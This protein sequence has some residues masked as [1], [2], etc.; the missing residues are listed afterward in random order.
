MDW[1]G[2]SIQNPRIGTFFLYIY[3]RVLFQCDWVTHSALDVK[4]RWLRDIEIGVVSGNKVIVDSFGVGNAIAVFQ[5]GVLTDLSIDPSEKQ[6]FYPLL[7]V[8][9]VQVERRSINIGG[10]YIKLPNLKSGFLISKKKYEEG[11]HII[12]ITKSFFDRDKVQ[13]FSDVLKLVSRHFILAEGKSEIKFAK[14]FLNAERRKDIK[15]KIVHIDKIFEGKLSI[16]VRSSAVSVDDRELMDEL[17]EMS[18]ELLMMR[19]SKTDIKKV[20][21]DG[22]LSKKKVFNELLDPSSYEII[23]EKG[24]FETYGIWDEVGKYLIPK[25]ML[26]NGSNIIIEQTAAFCSIDVNSGTASSLGSFEINKS[27]IKEI[28]SN[29]NIRGISGKI[30]IDFLPLSRTLRNK[31]HVFVLNE[32]KKSMKNVIVY[33][34]TKGNSYEISRERSEVPLDLVLSNI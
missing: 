19:K 3:F 27:V 5:N 12:V 10:Y 31:L 33:G 32:F 8:L 15:D 6:F 1:S 28:V 18:E 34:W 21:S 25:F 11:E 9:V 22:L 2:W 16:L 17:K 30:I 26:A 23:E 4:I 13:K 24:I 20:I 7:S 29:V 14:G